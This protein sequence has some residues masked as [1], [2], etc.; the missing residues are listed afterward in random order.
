[1]AKVEVI[2]FVSLA[3]LVNLNGLY[4]VGYAWLFGMSVWIS[5]FGGVIAFKTLRELYLLI[6]NNDYSNFDIS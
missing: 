1:M 4:L 6:C 2:T 5:F 3:K